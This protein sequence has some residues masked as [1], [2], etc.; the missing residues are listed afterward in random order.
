MYNVSHLIAKINL[1]DYLANYR[2]A[3]RFMGYC[4]KCGK[5]NACWACP[6][7]DFDTEAYISSYEKAYIIG[8]K[9]VID[10]DLIEKNTGWERCTEV[11][12]RMI[13]EVRSNLDKKLL[14]LET[15]F[16][17]SRAFFA[18]TCHVCPAD[19]CTRKTGKPCVAPHNV[20]PALEAF[21]F[22]ISKTSA[23]LLNIEL[24]WSKNGILPEYLTLI[25]GF[26]IN[27]PIDEYKLI[28][29]LFN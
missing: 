23:Q 5:Y 28:K 18:G 16:P 26:F 1:N 29:Q 14:E 10:T 12:Y 27:Q 3:D 11:T 25:S 17:E 20:R 2:D 8:T 13:E 21:G 4:K 7:F 15:M 24:K 22:D 19:K 9:I 6:P